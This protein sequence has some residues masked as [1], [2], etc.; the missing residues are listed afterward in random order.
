MTRLRDR[1]TTNTHNRDGK[2]TARARLTLTQDAEFL[3]DIRPGT[4]GYKEFKKTVTDALTETLL[5]RITREY[6]TVLIELD[7]LLSTNPY[8]HRDR[9]A[10]LRQELAELIAN[11]PDIDDRVD[12]GT[13]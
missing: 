3:V 6:D 4:P 8:V 10:Q 9:I 11:G 5:R 7:I 12:S 1:I 13:G 2:V